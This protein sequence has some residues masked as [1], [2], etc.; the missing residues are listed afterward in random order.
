M[1]SGR[2]FYWRSD[3]EKYFAYIT[4]K[5]KRIHLGM[6]DT[7]VDA[8]AAYLR[9]KN[10]V[11]SHQQS[12]PSK[13]DHPCTNHVRLMSPLHLLTPEDIHYRRSS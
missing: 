12:S 5:K 4:I 7:I 2:G 8:R 13:A 11:N 9:A 10:L 1:R 6:F 3:V